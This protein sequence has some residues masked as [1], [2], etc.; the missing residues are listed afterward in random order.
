MTS[1]PDTVS[2]ST[3]ALVSEDVQLH[4]DGA[5]WVM[6]DLL[7]RVR[8]EITPGDPDVALFAGVGRS[9]DVAAYLT[10]VGQR[11]NE[12]QQALQ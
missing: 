11:R 6:D 4:T 8:L 7:G 5:D 2:T 9:N 1:R 12:P 10:G 3:Y